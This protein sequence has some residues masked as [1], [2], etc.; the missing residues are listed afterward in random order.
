MTM[1]SPRTVMLSPRTIIMITHNH[2]DHALTIMIVL[3]APRTILLMLSHTHN[4]D[5]ARLSFA[6]RT[7][8]P[9]TKLTAARSA[10]DW[11]LSL[12]AATLPKTGAFARFAAAFA[13]FNDP[14]NMTLHA[15]LPGWRPPG[16]GQGSRQGSRQ[17]SGQGR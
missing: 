4:P 9:C 10:K 1:L 7:V 14:R 5:H 6:A 13:A 11:R 3:N 2:D 12:R 15:H 8:L 17:G 16:G